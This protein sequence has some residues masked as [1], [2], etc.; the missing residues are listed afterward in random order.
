M[1]YHENQFSCNIIQ[2]LTNVEVDM[3]CYWTVNVIL[4][5]AEQR[6]IWL[7]LLFNNTPCLPKHKS[8]IV[9]LYNKCMLCISCHFILLKP[10]TLWVDSAKLL[11]VLTSL[12]V[13]H[14]I[15]PRAVCFAT[16]RP[17]NHAICSFIDSSGYASGPIRRC[18]F[19]DYIITYLIFVKNW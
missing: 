9:L 8:I 13:S 10:L 11:E 14:A 12:P 19:I 5:D 16:S 15:L 2:L 4:T 1:I 17:A 18:L 3:E 7:S 6:S